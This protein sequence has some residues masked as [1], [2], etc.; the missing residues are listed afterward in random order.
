MLATRPDPAAPTI[1]KSDG[2]SA[3]SSTSSS[4]RPVL[5]SEPSPAS[6][7]LGMSSRRFVQLP[8]GSQIEVSPASFKVAHQ[9]GQLLKPVSQ[10]SSTSSTGSALIVDYGEDK[11]YSSSFRVCHSNSDMFLS[12]CCCTDEELAGFQKP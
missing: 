1:L 8:V 10:E 2:S 7:I 4:F 6:M 9:I 3:S 11:T 5:S 12:R